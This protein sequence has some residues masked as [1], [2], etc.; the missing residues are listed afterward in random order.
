VKH[1]LSLVGLLLTLPALAGEPVRLLIV[2]FDNATGQA[3]QDPLAEGVADMLTACFSRH[4]AGVE[5]VDRGALQQVLDE[6]SLRWEG[7]AK[8]DFQVVAGRLPGARYLLRGSFNRGREG[9]T[10][11]AFLHD[12]ATTALVFS[13][14]ARGNSSGL[15]EAL[16]SGIAE[17]IATFLAGDRAARPAL[18]A[19]QAPE[20]SQL[21]I[22]GMGHYYNGNYAEAMPAFMKLLRQDPR[23]A[24]AQ[25]WLAQSFYKAG[26]TDFAKVEIK[27]FL[28]TFSDHS[29]HN[30]AL[31]LLRKIEQD[32]VK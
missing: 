3:R 4:A 20:T 9:L 1:W 12:I 23:N 32:D 5:I 11:S 21:L 17:R 29:R 19:D 16:C 10:V 14:E 24:Q 8:G 30:Q 25:F 6:Q 7:A 28:D 27:K 22:D 15:A 13:T 31:F 2:P 26:L 18:A